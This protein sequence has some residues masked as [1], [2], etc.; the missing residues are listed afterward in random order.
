MG[1]SHCSTD[2]RRTWHRAMFGPHGCV[3]CNRHEFHAT[4]KQRLISNHVLTAIV[5]AAGCRSALD[6]TFKVQSQCGKARI[7]P[8]LTKFSCP[9]L[10]LRKRQ[11]QG[12]GA[13]ERGRDTRQVTPSMRQ[14]P[15]QGMFCAATAKPCR[16]GGSAFQNFHFASN[17]LAP[18]RLLSLFLARC[19]GNSDLTSPGT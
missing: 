18:H 9:Q 8:G 16:S 15:G 14:V 17:A 10:K 19:E 7:H 11:G 12:Q 6:M 5:S 4:D 13:G 3:S 2:S 1:S